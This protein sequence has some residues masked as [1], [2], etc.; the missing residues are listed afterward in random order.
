M[1][2]VEELIEEAV[3]ETFPKATPEEKKE[4]AASLEEMLKKGGVPNPDDLGVTPEM[5]SNLYAF[6]HRLYTTGNYKAARAL[7]V[8]LCILDDQNALFHFGLA[9]CYHMQKQYDKA[10]TAYIASFIR[11]VNNPLPFFHLADCYT[12][13]NNIP[14]A[15]ESLK[16]V[17]KS[18]GTDPKYAR[19]KERAI[20]MK[21]HLTQGVKK[22]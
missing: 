11:D 4:R 9:S 12:N 14:A 22:G 18:T 21:D 15:V 6:A 1:K 17:I 19:I 7:F 20:L 16:W 3:A 5:M 2:A 10:K 13:L 8:W